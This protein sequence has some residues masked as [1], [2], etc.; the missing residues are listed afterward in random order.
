MKSSI[1]ELGELTE[2]ISPLWE[3][4]ISRVY[5][6]N[7]R[8]FEVFT[9]LKGRDDR[10]NTKIPAVF[11]PHHSADGGCAGISESAKTTREV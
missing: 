5:T 11:P 1:S 6:K 8:S 2:I 3:V 7:N 4:K 10:L 9:L